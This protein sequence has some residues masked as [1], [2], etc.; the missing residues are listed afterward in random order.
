M[1]VEKIQIKP[2]Q[3]K[4]GRRAKNSST[5]TVIVETPSR[6]A[7]SKSVERARSGTRPT[8]IKIDLPKR[9]P[10]PK[11]TPHQR[12]ASKFDILAPPGE[13]RMISE[14]VRCLLNPDSCS[15]RIP[16][17]NAQPS[18]VWQSLN[19]FDILADFSGSDVG[20]F[21]IAMKPTLGQLDTVDHYKCAIVQPVDGFMQQD[22]TNPNTYLDYNNGF[23]PR[24]DVNAPILTQ[25]SGFFMGLLGGGTLSTAVPFGTAPAFSNLNYG[26]G[27]EYN[28][29]TGMWT[30]PIGTYFISFEA[31]AGVEDIDPPNWVF[32]TAVGTFTIISTGF[33]NSVYTETAAVALTSAGTM[34]INFAGSDP[35]TS[36][37]LNILPGYFENIPNS[38]QGGLLNAYR[39]VAMSALFTATL[40]PLTSG[41][42]VS[43]SYVTKETCQKNFFTNNG[44][45]AQGVGQLQ[46]WNQLQR[47]PGAHNGK[48]NDGAYVWWSAENNT[49]LEYVTPGQEHQLPCLIISGQASSQGLTGTQLVG[50]LRV[51]CVYEGLTSSLLFKLACNR[52]AQGCIDAST[53]IISYHPHAM[54]NGEHIEW[55][56]RAVSNIFGAAKKFGSFAYDNRETI[57]S[58]VKAG[59][60][61]M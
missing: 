39:P 42:M 58:L 54:A 46:D 1:Q 48:Y 35:I 18:F 14:Y 56:K 45:V 24:I 13:G 26:L 53:R 61:L 32:G 34:G 3:K 4:Y 55:F 2:P 36:S 33:D 22:F 38:L 19:T 8:H 57:G 60:S 6:K 27:I 37:A 47:T 51:K 40:P 7:R 15:A 49:D 23:D 43:A 44:L 20:R 16:D 29:T 21:S 5:S 30:L 28:G 31:K 59:A 10:T 52:G 41:G 11:S 12:V 25:P 9:V 17:A 50:R